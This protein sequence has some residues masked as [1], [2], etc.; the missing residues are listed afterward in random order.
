MVFPPHI[1][2]L[3][4]HGKFVAKSDYWVL[5][6]SETIGP[7][8]QDLEAWKTF[9]NPLLCLGFQRLRC[10]DENMLTWLAHRG[11]CAKS[12][13]TTKSHNHLLACP[14]H[15]PCFYGSMASLEI[16]WKID[17]KRKGG[18]EESQYGIGDISTSTTTQ[19]RTHQRLL[20]YPR[21]LYLLIALVM[22]S[23][24]NRWQNDGISDLEEP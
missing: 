13:T 3:S 21:N 12:T 1:M 20:A 19:Y 18:F 14:W 11:P 22:G 2:P 16:W 4:S 17:G 7:S 15:R 6:S 9:L 5:P 24:E 10:D 8:W 23:P